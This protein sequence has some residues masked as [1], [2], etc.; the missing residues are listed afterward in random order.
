M[1]HDTLR[2]HGGWS[3]E[4]IH[5]LRVGNHT[6]EQIDIRPPELDHVIRWGDGR[7]A[8][9]LALLAEL[10][11]QPEAALRTLRYPDV[12]RVMLA[13]ANVIKDTPMHADFIKGVRPIATPPTAASAVWEMPAAVAAPE[14]I[15]GINDD[16]DPR[17][18]KVAGQVMRFKPPAPETAPPV[19]LP[20]QVPQVPQAPQAQ[21]QV[22][23]AEPDDPLASA[24]TTDAIRRVR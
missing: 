22:P 7:I 3:V 4:L 2:R 12:E 21:A 14:V 6:V 16:V 11:E 17:F 24:G 9:T 13:L 8:S 15:A 1:A 5:P 23:P 18:P 10:S 20:P 19:E